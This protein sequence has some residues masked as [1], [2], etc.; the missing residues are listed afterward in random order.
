MT[1]SSNATYRLDDLCAEGG[2]EVDYLHHLDDAGRH[3]CPT[4][5]LWCA[6]HGRAVGTF[7]GPADCAL[8]DGTND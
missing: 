8:F 3:Y 1:G 5:F 7:D 2:C 6:S 4:G